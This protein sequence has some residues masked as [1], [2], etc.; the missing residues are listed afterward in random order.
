MNTTRG[1]LQFLGTQPEIVG[2]ACTGLVVQHFYEGKTL[3]DQANVTYRRF[4][5]TW[6][7]IYFE[8]GTVFWRSGQAPEQAKNSTLEHGLLLNDL[9]ELPTVAGRT[10]LGIDYTATEAGD[11]AVQFNFGDKAV[12]R[13]RYDASADRTQIDA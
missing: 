3:V 13:L 5:D 10:L 12:L 4:A 8:S 2:H 11:V 7:R 9:T 6:H 1:D